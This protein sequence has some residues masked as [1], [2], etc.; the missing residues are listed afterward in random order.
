MLRRVDVIGFAWTAA[1]TGFACVGLSGC[2]GLAATESMAPTPSRVELFDALPARVA[3]SAWHDAAV[4]ALAEP[5]AVKLP[6]AEWGGFL[7][8]E[9]NARAMTFTGLKGQ[10]LDIALALPAEAGTL[11]SLASGAVTAELFVA[12]G[13]EPIRLAG[14]PLGEAPLTLRLPRDASYI[15]RL[16]PEPSTDAIYHVEL[17]LGAALP[18]PLRGYAVR[19]TAVNAFFGARRD[20]GTRY[21]EGVDIFAPRRTPVLA[22]ADGTA[23]YRANDLGGHSVWVSAPGVSYYYAH[24]ERVAVG[25]GQRVRAGDIIGYVGNSGN[26]HAMEPHLHFGVYEWGKKPIDPLPLL[27]SHRFEDIPGAEIEPTEPQTLWRSGCAARFPDSLSSYRVCLALSELVE[28]PHRPV[29]RQPC[30][31]AGSPCARLADYAQPTRHAPLAVYRDAAERSPLRLGAVY[32][33][34][35]AA[36][37]QAALDVVDG[38]GATWCAAETGGLPSLCPTE[39]ARHLF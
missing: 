39:R 26:A 14:I 5:T 18:S 6:H 10:R 12:A 37:S 11:A 31:P 28:R 33:D 32:A 38:V 27:K 1:F 15:V 29:D 7:S 8:H 4:R 30:A 19:A 17:E 20:G 3:E 22:V 2:D 13:P 24:L 36:P 21:H 23:T 35:P 9:P 34:L 25:G 16:T